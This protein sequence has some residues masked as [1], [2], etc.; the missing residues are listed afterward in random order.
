M[1][2]RK[3]EEGGGRMEFYFD[4]YLPL[5]LSDLI[6]LRQSRQEELIEEREVLSL[7]PLSAVH[8]PSYLPIS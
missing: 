4:E 8:C 7:Q 6:S 1:R 2:E 5:F 3:R